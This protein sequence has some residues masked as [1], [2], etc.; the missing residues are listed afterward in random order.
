[1]ISLGDI[2][3]IAFTTMLPLDKG[4]DEL[5]SGSFSVGASS[6]PGLLGNITTTPTT[7]TYNSGVLPVMIFSIDNSA[8]YDMGTMIY[9]AGASLTPAF[10]ATCYDFSNS[11]VMVGQNF[12]NALLTCYYKAIL[13]S[14]D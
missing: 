9:N 5:F 1:M 14:E 2:D 3:K 6:S 7:H 11:F 4:Y 8:W 13:L 10:S 12:T